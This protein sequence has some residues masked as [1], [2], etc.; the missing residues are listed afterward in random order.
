MRRAVNTAAPLGKRTR[1]RAQAVADKY[2]RAAKAKGDSQR[3]RKTLNE[4]LSDHYGEEL[5]LDTVRHYVHQWL[6]AR[7][8]E[9]SIGTF[10]RYNGVVEKF[11]SFLGSKAQAPLEEITKPQIL[12]FRDTLVATSAPAKSTVR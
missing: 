8:A 11:L 3:V 12:A 5:H 1:A 10:Q 4:F 7:K 9:T 6:A 2:E